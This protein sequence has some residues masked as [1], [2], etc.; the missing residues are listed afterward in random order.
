[1]SRLNVPD[2]IDERMQVLPERDVVTI[3]GDEI[4]G[5]ERT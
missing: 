4:W 5:I 1:M 2:V 3:K